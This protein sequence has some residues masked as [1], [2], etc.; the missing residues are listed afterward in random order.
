MKNDV[1]YNDLLGTGKWHIAYYKTSSRKWL[2]MTRPHKT[3]Q[4]QIYQND[5][6]AMQS[7][8]WGNHGARK[9]FQLHKRF[10]L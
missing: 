1:G 4:H 7:L 10:E 5:I 3:F 6:A 8:K 2:S 9:I